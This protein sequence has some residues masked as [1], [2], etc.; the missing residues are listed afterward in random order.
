MAFPPL[1][2]THH[3]AATF[4]PTRHWSGTDPYERERI[5][6]INREAEREKPPGDPQQPAD[7]SDA[8]PLIVIAC[9]ALA[10]TVI[11]L[12][13]IWVNTSSPAG[14][15]RPVAEQQQRQ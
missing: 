4:A 10:A 2:G 9:A 13:L 3:R 12:G 14:G 15:G 11:V 8:R 7:R 5:D 1:V 6:R